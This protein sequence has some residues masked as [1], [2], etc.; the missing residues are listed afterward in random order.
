MSITLGEKYRDKVTGFV[1]VATAH[2]RYLDADEQVQLSGTD[3]TGSIKELWLFIGR[4][5]TYREGNDPAKQTTG[6]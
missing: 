6:E 4:V 1:G 2:C 3:A 5:V